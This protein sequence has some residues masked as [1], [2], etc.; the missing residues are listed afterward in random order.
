MQQAILHVVYPDRYRVLNTKL[1]E[2]MA[3]LVLWPQHNLAEDSLASQSEA[4]NL[5]LLELAKMLEI[6][7]WTLDY[8]WWYV[9]ASGFGRKL[10]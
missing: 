5:I 9:A 3:K 1:K 2:G 6:D 8:L 10:P 7:L 4:V